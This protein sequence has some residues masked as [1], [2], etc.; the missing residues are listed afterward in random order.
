MYMCSMSHIST[1]KR[2]T[3]DSIYAD[4]AATVA[5]CYA[6]PKASADLRDVLPPSLYLYFYPCLSLSL[7]PFLLLLLSSSSSHI[8][9]W[10][11]AKYNRSRTLH[12]LSLIMKPNWCTPLIR[13]HASA[14]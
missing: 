3:N 12:S 4:V 10:Y 8:V 2:I 5:G 13:L 14:I 1:K 11:H 7:S 6:I 9:L